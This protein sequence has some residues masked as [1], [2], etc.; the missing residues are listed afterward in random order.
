LI[1]E[2]AMEV[3]ELEK[4]LS[5]DVGVAAYVKQGFDPRTVLAPVPQGT[6]IPLWQESDFSMRNAR[7][8]IGFSRNQMGEFDTSSRRT[9]T[10]AS[11]VSRGSDFRTDRRQEAVA[12]LYIRSFRKLNQIIFT[13]WKKPR[14]IQVGPDKWPTFTGKEIE[15]EYSY[16]LDFGS[17]RP[18]DPESRRM[19][20][21]QTYM[22]FRQDPFVDQKALRMYLAR[23]FADVEFDMLFPEESLSAGLSVQMSQMLG[24]T[25]ALPQGQGPQSGGQMQQM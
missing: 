16:R 20:A 2:G 22:L 8:A 13:F 25:G 10:E 15:A 11:L 5:P 23:N 12:R 21:V 24:Q 1:Q 9:A 17:D 19:M 18:K 14:L 3:S 7:S 6:N 4:A